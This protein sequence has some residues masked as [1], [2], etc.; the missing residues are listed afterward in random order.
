MINIMSSQGLVTMR[1]SDGWLALIVFG[2]VIF[3]ILMIYSA[4]VILGHLQGNDHVFATKQFVSACIGFTALGIAASIDYHI[5]QRWAG[6]ML[7]VTYLLLFSV[8][9]FSVGAI[10]GAHRWISLGGQTFQPSELAKLTFIMYV[11]A[12]LA[13]RGDR[14]QNITETFLPYLAVIASIS[15]LMLKEPDFGTLTIILVPAI[16]I[17]FVA[18]LTWKQVLLGL[19]L[20]ILS[21]GLIL[22]TKYRRDRIMTFLDPSQDTSGTSYHVKNI[23]IAIGSGGMW[24][25]GYGQSRQ[26]RLFLPEPH[27]D[28]IFA[29]IA[30]E[31][32]AVRSTLLILI[33]CTLIYRG[34]RVAWLAPDDFGRYLAVG[35]TTWFGFQTFI[36]LASM[37]HLVPLVGVPLP[38]ISYGGTSLMISLV[39][40]GVLL[41]ISRQ[42]II[43]HS[44]TPK[45]N[46]SSRVKS[47]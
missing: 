33:F 14:L 9:F 41:N 13:Q 16:V 19:V 1:R 15:L 7:G 28:S 18:G 35:I 32:G 42:V 27:T 30:E 23:A 45:T 36:N 4:S 39:A 38:F 21:L 2:L 31:L 46:R 20:G 29:I 43:P 26:K 34:F 44:S 12:W 5:W 37:L 17:Y 24:G 11:S 25:L 22:S 3:G 8:F 47:H 40:V 6:W 10:N